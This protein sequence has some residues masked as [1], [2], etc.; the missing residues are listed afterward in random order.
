MWG[1]LIFL[2]LFSFKKFPSFVVLFFVLL[3]NPSIAEKLLTKTEI[4]KKSNECL[5]DL[6][7]KVCV[8][9]FLEMEKI[10]L[11]ES[12][13]NRFKCQGSILGLQTEL[14][15]AYFFKNLKKN[16][17]GIMIPYVIKNC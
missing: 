9:L 8:N 11:V 16:K 17:K 1:N 10:Q 15:E 6:Q 12:D 14:I 3:P 7:Y 4:L 13:Q 2:N 5:N